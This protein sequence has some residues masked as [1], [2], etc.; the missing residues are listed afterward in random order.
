MKSTLF[1]YFQVTPHRQY[2]LGFLDLSRYVKDNDGYH[3]C[4]VGVCVMSR[5]GY[6]LPCRSKSGLEILRHFKTIY[7][8]STIEILQTDEGV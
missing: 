8:E 2:Q 1:Y 7:N 3:Y 4:L 5:F 6:G